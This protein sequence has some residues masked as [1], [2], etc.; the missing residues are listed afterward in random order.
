M[1]KISKFS[2][3]FVFIIALASCKKDAVNL[4]LKEIM[5]NNVGK[6]L[7]ES[8]NGFGID[9]FKIV[10]ANNNENK[11]QMISPL[12]VSLALSMA[13]NG[14]DKE[15]KTAMENTLQLTGL[16]TDEIN[17][18]NKQLSEALMGV[19][20]R[21]DF[22][23]ANS[24][25]Y[26]ENFSVLPDFITTNENF[27]N[28]EVRA[29]DFGNSN[30]ADVINNWV[31]DKTNDKI[32]KIVDN[33]PSNI[34]MYLINAIYFKGN[35]KYQFDKSD[36]QD[37]PFY[38]T[39]GT[40]KTVE[41][42]KQ[43]ADLKTMANDDFY[44]V[45]LEYGQGNFVMDLFLPNDD[46]NVLDIINSLDNDNW[47]S[48]MNSLSGAHETTIVLPPFKFEYEQL[49]NEALASMGMGIAFDENQSDFS[50]INT[51]NQLFIS[52][53]KHKTFIELNEKGTEAAAVTSVSFGITSVGPGGEI[54]F[55]KPFMFAI[56]E[57]STGAILF[58]GVLENPE[59]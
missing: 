29:L 59:R 26:K 32:I 52:E 19:D 17:I 56:R 42:M 34:V 3:I 57:V 43:T 14:A 13:Y 41:M 33:I 28:A 54:I 49:L 12:S 8:D 15:T 10:A 48:W 36:N 21:V 31:A 23:I 37:L 30:S 58:L 16:S 39:N 5:L 55:D 18:N 6:Q 27:Y 4:E 40:T 53:V 24:I 25:W 9:L 47:N 22:N 45:E 7:V 35:W 38:L 46:K 51:D 50:K 2:L 20:G 44:L 11:N 1:K